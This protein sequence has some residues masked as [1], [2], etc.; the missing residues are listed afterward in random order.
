MPEVFQSDTVIKEVLGDKKKYYLDSG[1]SWMQ[2][3]NL[4]FEAE[5]KNYQIDIEI[6][7]ASDV[8]Q[9]PDFDYYLIRKKINS[10]SSSV[11][12]KEMMGIF[13]TPIVIY[14]K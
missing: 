4:K 2:M 10:T 7:N 3:M 14:S 9:L 6:G 12:S 5:R 8:E 1:I 13:H 11:E